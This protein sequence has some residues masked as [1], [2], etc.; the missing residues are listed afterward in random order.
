MSQSTTR[1]RLSPEKRKQ[2]LLEAAIDLFAEKGIGEAKHADIARRVGIS[3]AA[4]FVYFPTRE[5]LL[6]EVVDEVG[7]YFLT[8][9]NDL[10]PHTVGAP[11]ILKAL[12]ARALLVLDER[13]SYMKVWLGWSTR[14]DLEL[15]SRFMVVQE[16]IL[17]KVSEIL[18]ACEDSI[19]KENRDDARIL[20]SASHTLALMKLDGEPEEKIE[21]FT[22]HTI[23]VVLAYG[24]S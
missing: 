8:L 4:T 14:F 11:A 19:S 17:S 10:E 20:L 1:K 18:W 13:P 15:R 7:R 22:D 23:Q 12:S 2:Q 6:E 24:R 5:A 3:T 9:F 16:Q 21:R